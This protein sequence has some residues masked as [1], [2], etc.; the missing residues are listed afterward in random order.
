MSG[1]DSVIYDLAPELSGKRGIFCGT[2]KKAVHSGDDFTLS[3]EKIG[4]YFMAARRVLREALTTLAVPVS[5]IVC[6]VI[7]KFLSVE[8]RCHQ[9]RKPARN[10][11][12]RMAIEL[13]DILHKPAA[14]H[15][16]VRRA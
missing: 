7:L 6:H 3:D 9:L 10:R 1:A 8:N 14:N 12:R 15:C 11:S 13:L 5:D 4:D 16:C 2:W